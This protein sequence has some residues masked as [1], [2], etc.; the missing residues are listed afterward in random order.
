M[1]IGILCPPLTQLRGFEKRLFNEITRIDGVEI[2]HLYFDGRTGLDNPNTKRKRLKR[3]FANN[4]SGKLLYHIQLMVEK[5]LFKKSVDLMQ[6]EEL[7]IN[8]D[9]YQLRYLFPKRK[10]MIDVFDSSDA[11]V[12]ISDGIDLMLRWEF[13]IIHGRDFLDAPNYGIWSLHHGDNNK[14]RGGPYCFWEILFHEQVIGVTLQRLTP[15]LDG[16]KIIDKAYYNTDWSLYRSQSRVILNSVDLVTKNIKLLRDGIISSKDSPIYDGG[17]FKIPTFNNQLAY[18]S[19]FYNI[20]LRKLVRRVVGKIFGTRFNV[21]SI[22]YGEGDISSKPLFRHSVEIKPPSGFFYADPFLAVKENK[23]YLFFENYNYAL[24][25]GSI[26][27]GELSRQ[28]LISFK[29]I[30]N[31]DFHYS[32]PFVFTIGDKYFMSPETSQKQR[33][34]VY[35][36]EAFPFKWRLYSVLFEGERILDPR[37]IEI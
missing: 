21:W 33:M 12:V 7:N 32:Y 16:G 25:K 1:K 27:V 10:G 28:G 29:T 35:V 6:R 14:F 34:E 11:A 4:S 30:F 26:C 19:R 31:D 24:R 20:L 36:S 23:K 22:L 9:N 37:F 3:L 5:T 8:P 2:T 13:N 18:M 17:L 15:E